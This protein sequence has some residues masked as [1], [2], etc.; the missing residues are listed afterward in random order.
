MR[1]AICHLML[2]LV[3]LAGSALATPPYADDDAPVSSTCLNTS[4]MLT[5]GEEYTRIWEL[6]QKNFYYR[7]RLENHDWQRWQSPPSGLSSYKE[8]EAAISEQL[9]QLEDPYTAIWYKR[10]KPDD[11][12]VETLPRMLK[13]DI[14]FV[15]I[16]GFDQEAVSSTRQALQNMPEAKGYIIDLRENHGGSVVGALHIFEMMVAEGQF[17]KFSAYVDGRT[18]TSELTVKPTVS[19]ELTGQQELR[20]ARQKNLTGNKP[21]I[22]LVDEETASAA[23]MLADALQ[24]NHR[25][26]LLGVTTYGKGLVQMV[27]KLRPGVELAVTS[28][29][30]RRLNHLCIHKVGI[31]PDVAL[32]RSG[33]GDNQL[34]RAMEL[35]TP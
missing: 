3:M 31:E 24:Y 20:D 13:G 8:A 12:L 2:L 4:D 18:R 34:R 9:E 26:R 6:V 35:L 11:Q 5:P 23:E 7:N 10:S 14:A 1:T 32:P 17:V 25:A 22:V 15:P 21:M 28:G 16:R 27:Y 19:V 30:W 33:A 29:R